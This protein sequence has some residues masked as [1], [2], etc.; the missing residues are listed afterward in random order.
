MAIFMQILSWKITSMIKL[1]D[2]LFVWLF[3][4]DH[5]S[6]ANLQCSIHSTWM[7]LFFHFVWFVVCKNKRKN[8]PK[9]NFQWEQRTKKKFPTLTLFAYIICQYIIFQHTHTSILAPKTKTKKN[10]LRDS[11]F[12]DKI[13]AVIIIIINEQWIFFY[14]KFKRKKSI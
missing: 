3:L 5:R 7:C 8:W 12:L 11:V 1:A 13:L 10:F 4:F 6:I 14:Y 9:K 2:H